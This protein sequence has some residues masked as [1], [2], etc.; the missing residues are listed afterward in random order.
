MRRLRGVL[1]VAFL[2]ARAAAATHYAKR[3]GAPGLEFARFGRAVAL[4]I[5]AREPRLAAELAITPVNIFRYFEFAF[6]WSCLPKTCEKVLD[7]GSPRLFSLFAASRDRALSLT[8]MNPD[9]ADLDMTRRL[10]DALRLPVLTELRGIETINEQGHFDCVWAIS[11]VEHVH[12]AIDDTEAVLRLYRA[13]RPGGRLLLTVPV[14]RR[15]RSEFRRGRHYVGDGAD[16]HR[17][18]F[19][20]H[21]YDESAVHERLVSP[22]GHEASLIRWFGETTPG[23]FAA[24]E[25]EWRARG[26]LVTA[27]D[28]REIADHYM[29]YPSWDTMPGAGVC[30]IVLEKPT[31]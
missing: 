10:A 11:V 14:D 4:R 19:F 30:G 23:H 8:M 20:Q 27:D 6:V 25:A 26:H 15:A 16:D 12:G 31:A 13:L 28:P 18:H 17:E 21:W 9:R 2:P 1:A 22:T 5:V 7:V 24:Y 29:E 3:M